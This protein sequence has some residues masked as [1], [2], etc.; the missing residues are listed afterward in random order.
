MADS[1][2]GQRATPC[3]LPGGMDSRKPPIPSS[4]RVCEWDEQCSFRI[5]RVI[6][7][8]RVRRGN[9]GNIPAPGGQNRTFYRMSCTGSGLYRQPQLVSLRLSPPSLTF[10][11]SL[12]EIDQNPPYSLPFAP[13]PKSVFLHLSSFTSPTD[14]TKFVQSILPVHMGNLEVQGPQSGGWT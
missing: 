2:L 3:C 5:E 4:S 10:L 6:C 13:P 12:V 9:V 8:G 11:M 7:S 1:F 14:Q